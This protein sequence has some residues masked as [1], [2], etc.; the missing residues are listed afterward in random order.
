MDIKY[1]MKIKQIDKLLILGGEYYEGLRTF[2]K[3]CKGIY[4]I[5]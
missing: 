1:M 3:I 2:I 4:N 5:R